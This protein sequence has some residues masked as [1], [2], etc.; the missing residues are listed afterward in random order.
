MKTATIREVRNEFG[1]LEAWL[2][3]GETIEI[4]RRGKPVAHLSPA[5][6]DRRD[7]PWAGVD[8][9]ARRRRI[10]GGRELTQSKLDAI[11]ALELEG[12]EG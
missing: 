9:E 5:S 12:Q 4:Q 8:F 6:S 11:E 10:S 7:S 2:A 3:E 1:K